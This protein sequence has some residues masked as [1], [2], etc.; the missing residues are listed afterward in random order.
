MTF[1]NPWMLLG[2]FAALIPLLVHLFDRRRPRPHPFGAISFVLRSQRRTAS[3]LK[4]KRLLLYSLRTL[5]LLGLPIALARPQLVRDAQAA[6][7]SRGAAATAIV[8][9]A[10]MS[11]QFADR[12]KLF[13]R[14]RE[15]ARQAL[16]DLLPDEPA[17]LLLCNAEAQ[18]PPVPDFNRGRLRAAIDAAKPSFGISEMSRCMNFAAR[19][20]EDSPLP[21]KRLVVISDLAA[22]A[23]RLDLPPPTIQGPKGERI[24]PEVIVRDAANGAASLPNRAV[25]DLKIDPS[26]GGG[27]RTF[28]FTFTVRNFSE[29]PVKDLEAALKI[30]DQVVAKGFLDIPAHGAAKKTLIHTFNSGGTYPGEVSISPDNLPADDRRAFVVHLPKQLQALVVNGEPSPI[31]YRD[32]AF[33]V[34]AALTAA[35]SPVQELIRDPE[36]AFREPFDHYDLLFLLNVSAP[37]PEVARRL[38][39]FVQRGGGLLISMGDRIEPEAYNKLLGPILPRG[40]RMVK[41]AVPTEASDPE[42]SAAKIKE[43]AFDHVLFL[44]FSG[45]AREGLTSARFFKYMLL[46]PA[47]TSAGSA[48]SSEVLATFDDG[49]PALAFARRGQGRVL[50]Y[51]ST[52][53]RDWTD[54]P[55]RTSFLPLI[56]RFGSFLS[57][58]LEERDEARARVG[59]MVPLAASAPQSIS[60]VRSPSGTALP[61]RKRD[62]GSALVGPIAEPGLHQV[63]NPSGEPIPELSFA[64]GLEASESDLTRLKPEE[65]SA[66]F[67]E[68]TMRAS[69]A[70]AQSQHVPFWTWLIVGAAIA[71]FLE[72]VLLRK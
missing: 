57:G 5:I 66:Y 9:D 37:P 52:V 30:S 27:P 35:G 32:E 70:D 20:L 58:S 45:K 41:T 65:L 49:A 63:F 44:P 16:A 23:F 48:A 72:G 2:A 69:V 25:V 4:L 14:G 13:E 67:G 26:P 39:E 31:R 55:L 38:I 50:L 17:T 29:Q 11:M 19:A 12:E 62:D 54:L 43:V 46:E 64:A 53:D 60:L 7:A 42:A 28:Q 68:E 8:L 33:F 47:Q 3:R 36:S 15:Q 24:R 1:A 71:F 51:T 61:L 59:A 21:G 10:S 34:D 56:Q 6:T 18:P 40:L 22:H